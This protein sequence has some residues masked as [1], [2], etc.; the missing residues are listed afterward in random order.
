[1]AKSNLVERMEKKDAPKSWI[2]EVKILYQIIEKDKEIEAGYL[3]IIDTLARM[4]EA[5]LGAE[6]M[7]QL[8]RLKIQLG[9]ES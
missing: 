4:N 3:D 8:R 1:M 7:S 6:S 9:S 5:L 2:Q